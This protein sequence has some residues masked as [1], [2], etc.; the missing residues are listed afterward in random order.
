MAENK[1]CDSLKLGRNIL[2]CCNNIDES[3]LQYDDVVRIHVNRHAE[4]ILGAN[5]IYI[6][7]ICLKWNEGAFNNY[8]Y[9]VFKESW[10]MGK[11]R[12]ENEKLQSLLRALPH[13][14]TW[15][16]DTHPHA[17]LH[18]NCAVFPYEWLYIQY[19]GLVRNSPYGTIHPWVKFTRT[20]DFAVCEAERLIWTH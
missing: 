8:G 17:H 12:I 5:S 2:H 10:D 7:C 13:Q 11:R 4:G 15:Q 3:K 14:D 16:A 6:H 20:N 1:P 19:I 18:V 9:M